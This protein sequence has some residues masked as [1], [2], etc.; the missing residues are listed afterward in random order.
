MTTH[1]DRSKS[2]KCVEIVVRDTYAIRQSGR[3]S[4]SIGAWEY[5]RVAHTATIV[6]SYAVISTC[7][8]LNHMETYQRSKKEADKDSVC[9]SGHVDQMVA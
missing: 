6:V 3:K 8:C 7:S 2:P 1:V 9:L 4:N 5:A